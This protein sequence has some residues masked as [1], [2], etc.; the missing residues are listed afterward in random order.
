MAGEDPSLNL[1][2]FYLFAGAPGTTVMVM[3]VNP[4]AGLSAGDTFHPEGLY[5]F[6]FDLN[7][8][9]RE[10]VTFTVRFEQP[11]HSGS[12]EYV[13]VQ[14]FQVRKATGMDATCG[15]K[16]DVLVEAETGTVHNSARVRVYAGLARELFAGDA[17]ALHGFLAAFYKEHRYDGNVWQPRELLCPARR[18]PP[19]HDSYSC[20]AS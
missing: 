5:A 3:T 19:P 2:D 12:D 18:L 15:A 11:R 17:F 9:A 16:G 7:D 20:K 8:D 1:C 13:H 4:D 6:R 14:R 10:E